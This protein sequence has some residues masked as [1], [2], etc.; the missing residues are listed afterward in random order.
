M[1][2]NSI[3]LDTNII[4]DWLKGSKLITEK[5]DRTESVFIPSIVIGELYFGATHSLHVQKNIETI[6]RLTLSYTVLS[7]DENIAREYGNI[8]CELLRK[9]RPIPENDIWI[10]ALARCNNLVLVTRD[11]HFKEIDELDIEEWAAL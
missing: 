11:K 9:G 6:T 8:K 10:A 2:G 3:L 1:T 7:V 4:I 5:I